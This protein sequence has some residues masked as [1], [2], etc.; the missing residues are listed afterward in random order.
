MAVIIEE[1]RSILES[2]VDLSYNNTTDDAETC[3]EKL[4]EAT[5]LVSKALDKLTDLEEAID[6]IVRDLGDISP[7]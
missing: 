6:Q 4:D 7:Q 5:T 1:V 2:I 3:I